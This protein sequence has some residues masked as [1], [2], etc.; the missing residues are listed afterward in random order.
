MKRIARLTALAVAAGVLVTGCATPPQPPTV[1]PAPSVENGGDPK[2]GWVLLWDEPD[3]SWN[4]EI[5]VRCHGTV[6]L[7][8][9][10]DNRGSTVPSPL[11]P[12]PLCQ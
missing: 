12:N 2:T 11:V 7:Y 6:L 3:G 4:D 9:T 10:S 1:E 8:Q 5:Y